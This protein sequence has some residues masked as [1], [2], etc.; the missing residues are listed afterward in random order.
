MSI[1]LKL[2]SPPHGYESHQEFAKYELALGHAFHN[3]KVDQIGVTA[4]GGLRIDCILVDNVS[5]NDRIFEGWIA[6]LI[7]DPLTKVARIPTK[8]NPETFYTA[9]CTLMGT[10]YRRVWPILLDGKNVTF[11]A[12]H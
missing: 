4:D 2:V 9:S 3:L 6:D 1:Q 7:M 11:V 10:S 5:L 12:Y 8:G